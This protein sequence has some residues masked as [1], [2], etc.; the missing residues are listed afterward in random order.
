MSKGRE[1][2]AGVA[3]LLVVGDHSQSAGMG[4]VVEERHVVTCAHVVNSALGREFES[5]N[6]PDEKIA[7]AFPYADS[8]AVRTGRVISWHPMGQG[9]VTDV[10]VLELVD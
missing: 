9:R 1:R 4:I 10:A 6:K 8:E 5:Q 2:V 3:K 7:I